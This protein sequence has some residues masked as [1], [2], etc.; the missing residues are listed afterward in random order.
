MR[1]YEVTVILKSDLDD[2]TRQELI[3][4]IAEWLTHGDDE[5]AKP[6][7]DLW[8]ERQLA[9]PIRDQTRG[10]YVFYLAQLD[11]E[12]IVEIERNMRFVEDLLRHLIV[13]KED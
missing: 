4:R 3:D 9:Y 13:R 10:Y 8:G 1:E 5:S 11:A 12:R 6:Q 2:A 7:I